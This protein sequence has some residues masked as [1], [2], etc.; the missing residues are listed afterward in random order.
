MAVRIG[1]ESG[2]CV[3]IA[4][5]VG[6]VSKSIGE[7]RSGHVSDAEYLRSHQSGGDR[8]VGDSDRRA[9][10]RFDARTIEHSIEGAAGAFHRRNTSIFEKLDEG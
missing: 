8:S 3:S 10:N 6:G 1:C 2:R 9:A 4:T 7:D 5:V